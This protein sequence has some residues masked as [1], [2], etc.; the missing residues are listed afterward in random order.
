M[1]T[2]TGKYFRQDQAQRKTMK[3]LLTM[4][5]TLSTGL[6]LAADTIPSNSVKEYDVEIIIF[7]DTHARYLSSQ[8]WGPVSPIVTL[9]D[10]IKTKNN[11]KN[12]NSVDFK[13]IK[14]SILT[15]KY[16]KINASAKYNVLF[17]GAWR[18]AGLDKNKAFKINID[19]L[20]VF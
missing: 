17:Y 4:L 7:E 16:K 14:P 11:S 10:T 15:T 5:L 12:A 1:Y 2:S 9:N 6:T 3:I 19:A 20:I 18:Q 8:T 13:S